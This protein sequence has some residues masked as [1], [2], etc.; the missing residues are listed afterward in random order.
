MRRLALTL[1]LLATCVAG[2]LPRPAV[3]GA[4]APGVS[5]RLASSGYARLPAWRS[6]IRASVGRR[7]PGAAAVARIDSCGTLS[8]HRHKRQLQR[9]DLEPAP[10]PQRLL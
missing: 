4:P 6:W 2:G 3:A 9:C 1:L 7:H 8:P 5:F 10:R